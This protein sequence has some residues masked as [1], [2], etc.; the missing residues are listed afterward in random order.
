MSLVK[1]MGGMA[2]ISLGLALFTP[3]IESFIFLIN[4]VVIAPS[5]HLYDDSTFRDAPPRRLLL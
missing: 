3:G 2:G 4:M 1:V 5:T